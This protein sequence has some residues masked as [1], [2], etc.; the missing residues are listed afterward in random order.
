M[1]SEELESILSILNKSGLK[2]TLEREVI[3]RFLLEHKDEHFSA[4]E[5]F[6][7]VR[8]IRRIGIATIYRNLDLL[9]ELHIIKKMTHDFPVPRYTICERDQKHG[10]HMLICTRC[11][12]V[13]LI[14]EDWLMEIE[15]RLQRE[16]GFKVMDH[17]LVF[18][19][20]YSDCQKESCRIHGDRLTNR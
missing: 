6:N 11:K 3:I 5:I 10:S 12:D 15:E 13:K 4:S 1:Q 19:G 8:E 7:R 18:S 2:M 17:Q 14:K 9:I 16:F 20:I